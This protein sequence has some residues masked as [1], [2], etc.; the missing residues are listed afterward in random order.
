MGGY[1]NNKKKE[2]TIRSE[3]HLLQK[4]DDLRGLEALLSSGKLVLGG[5]M[6]W[7]DREL[8]EVIEEDV[9]MIW[10]MGR[11][12]EELAR[13]MLELTEAGTKGL[14]NPVIVATRFEVIVEEHKGLN[15]CPW[16]CQ[17]LLRKRTTTVKQLSSGKVLSW[18][19]LS[20]HLIRRHGFFQGKGSQYRLE[21]KELIGVVF[22]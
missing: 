19:D 18:T 17:E 6:G 3:E 10:A 16:E 11:S 12:V 9:R 5:F 13:G 7:D 20:I 2:V 8:Y 22:A 1:M 4:P 21:P 14:G 15:I